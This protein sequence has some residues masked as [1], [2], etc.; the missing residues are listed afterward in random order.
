MASTAISPSLATTSSSSSTTFCSQK[1]PRITSAFCSGIGTARA[2]SFRVLLSSRSLSSLSLGN[3]RSYGNLWRKSK[4]G[5]RGIGVMCSAAAAASTTVPQ[6][7][8]FDCDGVL[9]DTEKDGHRISF[10]E[11]FAEV[12]SRK[13]LRFRFIH[14]LENWMRIVYVFRLILSNLIVS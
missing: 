7:L 6:A 4:T 3:S 9:V 13:L 2:N 8:L 5:G 14:F 1:P 11:T 12:S 10:N